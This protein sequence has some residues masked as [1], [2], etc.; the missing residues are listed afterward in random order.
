MPSGHFFVGVERPGET[1]SRQTRR[2]TTAMI[3]KKGKRVLYD[4]MFKDESAM[5]R[6]CNKNKCPCNN[7]SVEGMLTVSV[8]K[9]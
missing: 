4:P 7:L 5:G 3:R 2:R 6:D 1:I 8:D 9:S